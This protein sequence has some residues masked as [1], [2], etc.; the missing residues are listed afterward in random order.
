MPNSLNDAEI[1]RIVQN[2]VQNMLGSTPRES[3]QSSGKKV[4][5]I[6][7]DHG[8]FELKEALKSDI[9]ALGFEVNDAGT[10]SKDAVDYPDFAHAVAQ[11]VSSGKAWRGIMIDGA[12]IGSCIVANKVPG[13][14]AGM[15]Y[16]ISSA[17]NSREH[18]DTNVLTLGAGL[19]G[20]ALARQIV[21]I[22]LTT[23]FGGDRHAKRVDKIKAVE[24][25]YLK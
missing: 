15:A 2:V 25:K 21:K 13:V 1:H 17:N 9:T 4:V 14:R 3:V 5:A 16:D 7:A 18:N 10:N 8:G 11:A 19:I 23:E 22:W 12:G 20:V 6:G 24:K